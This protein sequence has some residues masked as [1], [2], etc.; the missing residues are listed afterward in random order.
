MPGAQSARLAASRGA[1]QQQASSGPVQQQTTNWPAATPPLQSY[2]V[3]LTVLVAAVSSA[4]A[5]HL[6]A[7]AGPLLAP[8]P[9]PAPVL[10]APAPI[11]TAPA[12]I[13]HAPVLLGHAPVATS[14][15][16]A[17]PIAAHTISRPVATYST[18]Q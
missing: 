11:L 6:L 2:F 15:H 8:A 9:L 5:G 16:I 1:G 3:A 17:A 18:T 13:G 10:A 4:S 7:P 14:T 12:V